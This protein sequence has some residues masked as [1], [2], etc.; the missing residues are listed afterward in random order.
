[1]PSVQDHPLRLLRIRTGLSQTALAEEAHVT[2]AAVAAIEEGRVRHP[3]PELIHALA[4]RTGL[5]STAIEEQLAAWRAQKP[6]LSNRAKNTLALPPYVLGQYESFGQWRADIAPTVTAFASLTK[7]PRSSVARYEK[8]ELAQMP[9]PLINALYYL[10]AT[11]E[12]VSALMEV[13]NG[14]DA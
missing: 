7:C 9:Q 4:T 13:P 10:G 2:R 12:Y 1:M 6:A 11:P 3:S 8:G 14:Y 5:S